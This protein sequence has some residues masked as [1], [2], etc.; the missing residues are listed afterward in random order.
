MS[1]HDAEK[2]IWAWPF[3][4]GWGGYWRVNPDAVKREDGGAIYI[5]SDLCDPKAIRN[6]ALR[7]AVD[8]LR[9]LNGGWTSDD[10]NEC[11]ATLIALIEQEPKP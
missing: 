10:H 7:E 6:A 9:H 4:L 2:R 11:I 1:D 8:K 3:K 5:R